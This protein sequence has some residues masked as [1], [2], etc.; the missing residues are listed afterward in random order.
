[1]IFFLFYVTTWCIFSF[2]VLMALH[3]LLF[4]CQYLFKCWL[5][6]MPLHGVWNF[7][8]TSMC[9]VSVSYFDISLSV[10]AVF[11]NISSILS[12]NLLILHSV[13]SYLPIAHNHQFFYVNS[14]DFTKTLIIFSYIHAFFFL[15]NFLFLV[16]V[17][18][19]LFYLFG[20]YYTYF[21]AQVHLWS[22]LFRYKFSFLELIFLICSVIVFCE[23]IFFQNCSTGDV[24]ILRYRGLSG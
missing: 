3:G 8:A 19:S 23:F 10:W 2:R 13:V 1:M 21:K 9:L 18:Y 7:C 11:W 16:H 5:S 22:H 24:F 17:C 12:P 15:H 14:H 6:T 4:L 20:D